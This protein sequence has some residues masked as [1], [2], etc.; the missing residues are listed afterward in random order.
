MTSKIKMFIAAAMVAIVATSCSEEQ[1]TLTLEDIPGKAV[2][3]G[4]LTS[5]AGMEYVNNNRQKK[6][7][8]ASNQKVLIE[9][10]NATLVAGSKGYTTYEVTT[11][12]QGKFSQI[13]PVT[14]ETQVIIT[15]APFDSKS[16]YIEPDLIDPTMFLTKTRNAIFECQP[17][18]VTLNPGQ[19]VIK[20]MQYTY[21]NRN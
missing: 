9:V 17:K 11:D 14:S 12:S 19:S 5:D 3:S 1:T 8:A 13:V 10:N 15:P 7:V 16:Y 6:V 4:Y 18:T 2:I 21:T 20:D